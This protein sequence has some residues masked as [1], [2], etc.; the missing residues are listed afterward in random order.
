MA[1]PLSGCSARIFRIRRSSVPWTRSE[2]LLMACQ[3]PLGYRGSVPRFLS[4][5]KGRRGGASFGGVGGFDLLAVVCVVLLAVGFLQNAV[6]GA[7]DQL[8]SGS[9]RIGV[10]NAGKGKIPLVRTGQA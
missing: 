10:R 3:A 2:G 1:Q 8:H 9:V 4:V 7:F 5:S 6:D